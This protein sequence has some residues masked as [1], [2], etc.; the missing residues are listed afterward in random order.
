[1]DKPLRPRQLLVTGSIGKDTAV[2]GAIDFEAAEMRTWQ[3][4]A[5]YARCCLSYSQKPLSNASTSSVARI[6]P[7]SEMLQEM[8]TD[9]ML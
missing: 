2:S 8:V 6:A 1:M 3:H 4:R 5:T 7:V 9:S